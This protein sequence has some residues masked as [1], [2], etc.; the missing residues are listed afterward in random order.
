[1]DLRELANLIQASS[2]RRGILAPYPGRDKV[3]GDKIAQLR[4]L[5]EVVVIELPGSEREQNLLNCDRK[6]IQ[7]NGIWSVV[8]A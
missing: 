5:G 8:A 4:Q 3:L 1:M 2:Y 7:E 6:L